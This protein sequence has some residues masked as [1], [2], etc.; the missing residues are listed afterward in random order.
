MLS[1]TYLRS[2]G[3]FL[4]FFLIPLHIEGGDIYRIVIDPG[5]G[6]WNQKPYSKYGDKYDPISRR[7]LEPYRQGA[8]YQNRTEREIVLKLG[9][10][11]KKILDMTQTQKG[12]RQY[13]K[14][15]RKY[16]SSPV[17]P[18]KFDTLMTR[19][20][21]YTQYK[22]K[23]E[24]DRNLK[25]RLYDFYDE[26]TG[27][28]IQGRLSFINQN[29]PYLVISLHLTP[30]S[31]T[32]G[33]MAA[34]I[35]PPYRIFQTIR[36]ISDGRIDPSAFWNSPYKDWV[37]FSKEW[38]HLENAISDTWMYFHGYPTDR[39][40]TKA[41]LR[42]FS[43]Y[44]QNM[45]TWAY[46]DPPG[47]EKEAMG[48]GKGPYARSHAEFLARGEFWNR[49]RGQ[50]ERWRRDGG[51][52]GFG[53][54]NLYAGNELLR[55]VQYG[56]RTRLSQH[57]KQPGPIHSPFISAYSLPIYTNAIVAFLEIGFIDNERDVDL[58]ETETEIIAESLAVGIYSLFRGLKPIIRENLP[59]IPKGLK[60]G[61]EKYETL[62]GKNYFH[63][64]VQ[65]EP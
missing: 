5:H 55:Y 45:I 2:S 33:G 59:Y 9:L 34:V 1:A 37:K 29:A 65:K 64:S 35:A 30:G 13:E 16:S 23:D 60:L 18:L 53:G 32:Q 11:I 4:A 40:G 46:A 3:L 48:G 8:I 52:E 15:I 10:Q 27:R 50:G 21:D 47:W 12:F 43:G 62:H 54:D 39:T 44:R 41:D 42:K 58:L 28:K 57:K 61:F 56:L 36:L 31:P 25:Y 22:W 51:K 19:T 49:E 17:Q 6:G 7:F 63:S 20:D 24:D 26:K 14:L 38:N